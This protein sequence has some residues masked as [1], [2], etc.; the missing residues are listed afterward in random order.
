MKT[1]LKF[2]LLIFISFNITPLFSQNNDLEQGWEAFKKNEISKAK[3]FF[4]KAKLDEKSKQDAHLALALMATMGM[5]DNEDAFN[6]FR[7]FVQIADNPN[8]YLFALWN[9]DCGFGNQILTKDKYKY[10]KKELLMSPV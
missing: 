8:A 10:L 2:Y 7:E 1:L 3:D 9:T 5:E 4:S 6:E